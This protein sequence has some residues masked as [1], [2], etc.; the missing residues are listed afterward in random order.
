MQGI[1][2]DQLHPGKSALSLE[3][4]FQPIAIKQR[5]CYYLLSASAHWNENQLVSVVVSFA[6]EKLFVG[7]IIIIP[8]F[9]F[10][11]I[12]KSYCRASVV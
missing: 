12:K 5:Q 2:Q 8:R 9:L 11:M 10:Q 1:H 4:P 3:G 7:A 6:R